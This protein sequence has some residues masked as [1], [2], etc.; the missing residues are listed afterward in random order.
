[1][2]IFVNGEAVDCE[3]G[4][5][6]TELVA[7]RRLTPEAILVE[8]NGIALPRRDWKERSLQENDR[9]EILSVAAGG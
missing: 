2:R 6:I 9:L 7:Q 4:L 3:A 8:Q 5:T 1:M